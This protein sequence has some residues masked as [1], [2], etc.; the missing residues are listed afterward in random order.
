MYRWSDYNPRADAA[1][2]RQLICPDGTLAG[3][4]IRTLRNGWGAYC[5]TKRADLAQRILEALNARHPHNQAR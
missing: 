2:V 3:V 1:D 4:T 5:D